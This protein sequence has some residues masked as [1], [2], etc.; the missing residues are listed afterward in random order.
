MSIDVSK[1]KSGDQY[2]NEKEGWVE[3][4]KVELA[5]FDDYRVFDVDGGRLTVGLD[6]CVAGNKNLSITDVKIK[7]QP[8]DQ[9]TP[10]KITSDGGSSSY[11]L[12]PQSLVDLV[13]KTGKLE[14]K[15]IIRHGFG[16]DNDFG[17]VFKALKRLY[18]LK[19]GG[20]K[21]GSTAEYEVN[22]MKYFLNEILEDL[23]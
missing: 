16:N 12:F 1:L 13:I 9:E 4:S 10:S 8:S 11:Y 6:G 18:E 15:D 21:D 17:N 3:I 20:G 23:K 2:Y 7:E 5:R 22:K 14:T 19:L